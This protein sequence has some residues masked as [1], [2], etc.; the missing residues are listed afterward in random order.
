M[1]IILYTIYCD[2]CSLLVCSIA[3]VLNL[4]LSSCCGTTIPM[5]HCKP[6]TGTSMSPK[7][8]GIMGIVVLQQLERHRLS[9]HDLNHSIVALAVFLGS[10]SYWKVNLRPSLKSFA[11]SNRFSFKVSLYLA[12]TILPSTLTSFPVP[13]E[14]KHLHN[15]MLPPPC[16]TVGMLCSEWCAVLVFH[17]T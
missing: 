4:W 16:F 5:R 6:L 1:P 2:V 12:P 11:V 10:L 14:E 7:G 9:T 13:A 15:M 17:H 8:W 3:W